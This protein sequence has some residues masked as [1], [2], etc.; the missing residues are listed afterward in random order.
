[1]KKMMFGLFMAV[2]ASSSF[3]AGDAAAGKSKAAVCGAC[4]GADGNSA[5]PNFPSLAGQHEKYIIKQLND[6]KLPQAEGGRVVPEMMGIAEAFQTKIWKTLPRIT[7]RKLLLVVQQIR[8]LQ[9]KVNLFFVPAL[10]VRVL[11]RAQVVMG[12]M[13]RV[14]QERLSQH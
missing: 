10:I 3:A 11:H 13:V 12:L 2:I 1:M 4:H 8:S 7:H 14:L 5:V 6:M 9:K